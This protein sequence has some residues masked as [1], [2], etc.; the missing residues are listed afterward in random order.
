[1]TPVPSIL[2]GVPASK[3]MPNDAKASQIFPV[4]KLDFPTRSLLWAIEAHVVSLFRPNATHHLIG[5]L[6]FRPITPKDSLFAPKF[7][8]VKHVCLSAIACLL[9]PPF[10]RT[11][12]LVVLGPKLAQGWAP[13]ALKN[14]LVQD[15]GL[16]LTQSCFRM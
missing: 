13:G 5:P 8:G 1:M 11:P 16:D 6:S 14:V 12:R 4:R 10:Q 3:Y 9:G 7:P 15:K 2:F